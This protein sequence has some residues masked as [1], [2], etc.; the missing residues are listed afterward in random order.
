MRKKFI[1]VSIFLSAAL[2]LAACEGTS[3]ADTSSQTDEDTTSEEVDSD[4]SSADVSIDLMGLAEH[5][6]TGDEVEL[7]ASAEGDTTEENWHWYT[8][9]SDEDEWEV[10]E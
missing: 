7:V 2:L 6:H 4:T 8:R 5:Y 3:S 1:N 10:L 9:E